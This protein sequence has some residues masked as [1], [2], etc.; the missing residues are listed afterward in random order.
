MRMMR[1]EIKDKKIIAGFVL[2]I[3]ALM[4]I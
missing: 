1:G 3:W 4:S 2:L